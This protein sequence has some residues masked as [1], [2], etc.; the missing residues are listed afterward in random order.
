[1]KKPFVVEHIAILKIYLLAFEQLYLLKHFNRN[2]LTV[3][4]NFRRKQ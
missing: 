1:M 4:L 2:H 3:E